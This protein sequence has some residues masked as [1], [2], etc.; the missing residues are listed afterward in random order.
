[1]EQTEFDNRGQYNKPE[2]RRIDPFIC[3][4]TGLLKKAAAKIRENIGVV[5]I[6]VLKDKSGVFA[7]EYKKWFVTANKYR[8]KGNI[9][10]NQKQI[11]QRAHRYQKKLVVYVGDDD[12]FYMFDPEKILDQHWENQRGYI[13]MYNYDVALGRQF[14][15]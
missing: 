10:S 5:P 9:L 15:V 11:I 12:E 7:I 6:H 8:Y 3:G 13:T 4:S 2:E 14:L 1:M